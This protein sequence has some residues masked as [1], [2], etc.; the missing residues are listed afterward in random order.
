MKGD[1]VWVKVGGGGWRRAILISSLSSGILW[2]PTLI[3]FAAVGLEE[4]VR[5]TLIFRE[6][7]VS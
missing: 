3:V 4:H 2:Y 6:S 1:Y 5:N 7:S